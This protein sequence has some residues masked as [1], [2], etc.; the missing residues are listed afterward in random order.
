LL[1]L[2]HP[3]LL[4]LHMDSVENK[5]DSWQE[6]PNYISNGPY[7][8]KKWVK[9]S[10]IELVPNEKYWDR[11]N[12]HL[13]RIEVQLVEPTTTGTATVPYEDNETDVV[14]ITEADVER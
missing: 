6:P 12:V 11:K 5:P 13:D 7:A 4:P 10:S 14:G 3:A 8:V 2:T 1:A 9:N